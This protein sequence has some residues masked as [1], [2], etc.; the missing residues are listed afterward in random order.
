[1]AHYIFGYGS[2]LNHSSVTKTCPKIRNVRQVVLTGYQ[3]KFNATH[4]SLPDIALN[5]VENKNMDI[6]GVL[7]EVPDASLSALKEREKGY[8]MIEVTHLIAP[9]QEQPVFTFIAPDIDNC[10][11]KKIYQAYIDICLAGVPEE[12]RADWL[13]EAIIPFEISLDCRETLYKLHK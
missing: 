11:G 9:K 13:S 4:E 3:R 10:Q 5:I 2:L 7:L 6:E 12:K 8:E 1:M